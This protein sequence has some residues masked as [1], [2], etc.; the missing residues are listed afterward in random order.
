[1]SLLL[2]LVYALG[3]TLA[4][5]WIVYRVTRAHGW[6]SVPGRFGFRLGPAIHGS[7]WLHGSSVGE[8]SLLKPL[9]A[10]LERDYPDLPLVISSYTNTGLEAARA[11]YPAHR[12]LPFPLDLS[13][14]AE[15]MLERLGTQAIVVVESDFWPN[16]L[17][18]AERRG[19]PVATVNAKLS[20][21][22][23]RIHRL[24]RLVPRLMRKFAFVAAQ[25]PEHAERF[26]DLGVP[27]ERVYV[28]GNMKYDLTRTRP[29]ARTREETRLRLGFAPDAVV[30]IGGS[31]H[32]RED[33]VL[34]ESF[35]RVKRAHAGAALVIVPRYPDQAADT[36]RHALDAGFAAALKTAVDAGETAAPGGDGVLVVD[37]L[38]ELG[39]L[40]AAA[41]VAFVGG[42]L[43]YRGPNK[44]GHN[45]MEPAITGAPVLFGPYNSSFKETAAD[46]LA[47][48]GGA[49]VRDADELG[50]ALDALLADAGHRAAVGE[51]ARQVVLGGQGATLRNFDLLRAMIDDRCAVAAPV[52]SGDNAVRSQ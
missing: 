18:V 3:L 46:L 44:G 10:L 15:R 37:T 7:I 30:I 45:L 27:R 21:K 33:L 34:L 50:H 17:A 5:P 16:F 11:A 38:G 36:C 52:A 14:V 41:D 39:T 35:S 4:S 25:T 31:L 49:L 1:M 26:H 51:R 2:N 20:A 9:V 28:T 22:S 12:V 6:H 43:F 23:F 24:T 19:I 29:A 13:F 42:S 47:A 40:Y 32:P 48:D 8:V